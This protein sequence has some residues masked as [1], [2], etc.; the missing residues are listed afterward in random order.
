MSESVDSPKRVLYNGKSEG[1]AH[2]VDGY[3][4]FGQYSIAE[5]A[6]PDLRDGLKPV[7][8]RVLLEANED[9]K[10]RKGE[11]KKSVDL[12]GRT[13]SRHP[14]GDGSIYE[15]MVRMTDTN[16]TFNVPLLLGDGNMSK[17]YMSEG[18]AASRYTEVSMHPNSRDFFSEMDGVTLIRDE[19]E[20]GWEPSALP[21]R[22]PYMLCVQQQGLAVSVNTQTPSFNFWDVL[23]LTE[24]YIRKS[25]IGEKLD[26]T[27]VIYP[28]FSTGGHYIVDNRESLKVMMTGQGSLRVRADVDIVGKEI[29]INEIPVGTT[30]SSIIKKL[31]AI[32]EEGK[33]LKGVQSR[34]DSVSG[35]S[36]VKLVIVCRTAKVIQ[37]TLM[38][39]YGLNILQSAFTSR[40]IAL[41]GQYVVLGGVYNLVGQW[42]DWRKSVVI[43]DA[44]VKLASL[45]D[46]IRRIALFIEL[47][48]DDVSKAK[49]L[50]LTSKVSKNA[51]IKY[52]LE[53][54]APGRGYVEED[55][56]WVSDRKVSMFLDGG[57]Y[58]ARY[59]SLSADIKHYE[60][61]IANVEGF[62]LD[63]IAEIRKEHAG[64]HVRKTKL[65]KQDYRFTRASEGEDEGDI[66]DTSP[67]WFTMYRSG[68]LKK[69]RDQVHVSA[70]EVLCQVQAPA[71]STLI[72]F[73][74]YGQVVRVY[75]EQIPFQRDA[76]APG[77]YVPK[78]LG[79]DIEAAAE[80]GFD[81][82]NILYM[83]LLD[84]KD[85]M[86]LFADGKV[87]F[88]TTAKW[89]NVG[90]RH[91]I[92]S[93]GVNAAVLEDLVDVI[94][95]NDFPEHIVVVDNG[96]QRQFRY[97]IVKFSEIRRPKGT[98][99][100]AQVFKGGTGK[101]P[102][103]ITQWAPLTAEEASNWINV[104]FAH[105]YVERIAA[106]ATGDPVNDLNFDLDKFVAPSYSSIN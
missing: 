73:T 33:Y 94:H 43:K 8:R 61:R 76:S 102:L 29:H 62:L 16:G 32:L 64:S 1:F 53:E 69:T 54:F 36:D 90:A 96:L 13:T 78:Y 5:R 2:I 41:K 100:Q 85:R 106:G 66:T 26:A 83:D 74:S 47:V 70:G 84:G 46:E 72:G 55:A 39:L 22:Y 23:N 88:L 6:V 31:D 15:A 89:T 67:A 27:D 68:F 35:K 24:S 87:S 4:D 105:R 14:H 92:V 11:L 65:T 18:P 25:L 17:V 20:K 56:V 50:E 10:L 98:V 101:Y 103:N 86:L 45:A 91:K 21:V 52:L 38:E 82:F 9:P 48:S 63:D 12:V 7:Q 30:V 40:M 95:E 97:G 49:Y 19:A 59:E 58:R 51:A 28:D 79:L 77:L 34:Y 75:G 57:T 99:G 3:L 80:Q 71:N 81:E 42:V 60:G 93:S 104:D 44:G 37:D